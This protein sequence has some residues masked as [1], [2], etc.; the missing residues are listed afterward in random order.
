[1]LNTQIN[2]LSKVFVPVTFYLPQNYF[3][4]KIKV[5]FRF[6]YDF[7]RIVLSKGGRKNVQNPIL[8]LY[9]IHQPQ[10]IPRLIGYTERNTPLKILMEIMFYNFKYFVYNA[11]SKKKSV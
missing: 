7:K 10:I 11:K 9:N 2:Y 6:T 1:M 4:Q 3:A 8:K 5:N